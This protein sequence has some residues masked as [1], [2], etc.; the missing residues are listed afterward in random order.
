[1][2]FFEGNEIMPET[3]RKIIDDTENKKYV[4][5]ASLWELAIKLSGG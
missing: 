5:I 1:M 4:S 2:W 3:A